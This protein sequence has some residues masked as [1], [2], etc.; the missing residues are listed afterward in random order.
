MALERLVREG[1]DPNQ[2]HPVDGTTAAHRAVQSL[3][4]DALVLL[5]SA[6]AALDLATEAV[7]YD[8]H[9]DAWPSGM[10]ARDMLDEH[11]RRALTRRDYAEDRALWERFASALGRDLA[12]WC[13]E[14]VAT[15]D[16]V[17]GLWRT[18]AAADVTLEL[19]AD[20]TLT[21]L[22]GSA[23]PRQGEWLYDGRTLILTLEADA[24]GEKSAPSPRGGTIEADVRGGAMRL[25]FGGASQRVWRL[26][27]S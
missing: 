12:S 17:E 19:F 27:R 16:R 15:P 3:H 24:F 23:G 20:G 18:A 8:P 10:T 14:V 21:F 22:H 4:A 7:S 9:D 11:L 5:V 26:T 6:G 25:A 2:R 13:G 1:A